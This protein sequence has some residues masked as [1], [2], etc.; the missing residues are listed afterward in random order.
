MAPRALPLSNESPLPPAPGRLR[1]LVPG[2]QSLIGKVRVVG[3]VSA[4][5]A[6]VLWGVLFGGTVWPLSA[7]TALALAGLG[8]LLVPAAGTWLAVLTMREV[9]ELPARLRALPGR[10][11]GSAGE[12][13]TQAASVARSPGRH[14]G[15]RLIG[16]FGVLWRLREV[17]GDTRGTLLRTAALA[18]AARL[19]SLPFALALVA[20]F[21]LNFVVIAAA[22]A[23]VLVALAG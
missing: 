6:V 2:V 10:V 12:T 23:A 14:R 1:G 7:K 20:A 15:G 22:V 3:V 11:L 8:V 17:V 21:A 5:A 9:L 4:V 19:A 18:R 13:A 16:F